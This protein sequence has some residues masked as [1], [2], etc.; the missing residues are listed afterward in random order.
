M[1][2]IGPYH[3][4][5]M[6]RMDHNINIITNRDQSSDGWRFSLTDCISHKW[7]LYIARKDP[8][9]SLTA[10]TGGSLDTAGVWHCKHESWRRWKL[11]LHRAELTGRHPG[12]KQ[13]A[14]CASDFSNFLQDHLSY[15]LLQYSWCTNQV[16]HVEIKSLAIKFASV[17]CQKFCEVTLGQFLQQQP[18]CS[19][20]LL[21]SSRLLLGSL[22]WGCATTP[23]FFQGLHISSAV[24]CW[25]TILGHGSQSG[26]KL[27]TK[28]IRVTLTLM[29]PFRWQTLPQTL[30]V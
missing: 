11:Y 29:G 4:K 28:I 27:W 30:G 12:K 26:R 1:Y 8:I 13:N 17:S 5:G 10:K 3:I 18:Y 25:T 15:V 20:W 9:P 14:E 24:S 23:A 21:V 6:D 19:A 16:I 22:W 2:H 7:I